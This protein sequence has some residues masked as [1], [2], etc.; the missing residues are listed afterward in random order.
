MSDIKDVYKALMRTGDG[1]S[2]FLVVSFYF[3]SVLV[4]FTAWIYSRPV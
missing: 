4:I 3:A 2:V 1:R